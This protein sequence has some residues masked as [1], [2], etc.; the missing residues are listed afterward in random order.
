MY[1]AELWRYPVKSMAGEQ[2]EAVDLRA[3]GI[4]GDRMLRVVDAAGR[5]VTARTKP[6]LLS[7]RASLASAGRPFVNGVD[8]RSSAIARAVADVAGDGARLVPADDGHAFDESPLLIATD[9][10]IAA[11]GYDG[12]RFRPN[13][14][15]GGVHGMDERSW[16][17][18]RLR[19]G[20][21]DIDLG[22]LCA[23]CVITTLDP[24]SLERNPDVLRRVNAELGGK[25][26]RNCWVA[27]AG[28]IAI[29][30]PVELD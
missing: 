4:P 11:L 18:R 21:V 1:V 23:R 28:R 10:A 24:D 22:H 6:G 20:N 12:R 25:F 7:L 26:A 9:G 15:I 29:G 13:V 8:W 30:N 2:L 27:R 19:A 16:D 3:D 17:G 14:V 5:L